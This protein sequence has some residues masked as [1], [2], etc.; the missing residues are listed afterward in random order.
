MITN[1]SAFHLKIVDNNTLPELLVNFSP[2][3]PHHDFFNL[4]SSKHVHGREYYAHE[5]DRGNGPERH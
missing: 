4:G 3:F 1:R 2:F 5:K